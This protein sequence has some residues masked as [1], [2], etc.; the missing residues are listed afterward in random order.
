MFNGLFKKKRVFRALVMT[1]VLVTFLTI[2][3]SF[4]E[5][6]TALLFILMIALCIIIDFTL[7]K[8]LKSN[9]LRK[10]FFEKGVEQ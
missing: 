4:I 3:N 5:E 10:Y 2:F 9:R 1:V 6:K 7:V 8:I